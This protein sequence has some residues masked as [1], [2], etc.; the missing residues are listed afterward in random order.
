MSTYPA[1][2]TYSQATHDDLGFNPWLIRVPILMFGAALLLAMIFAGLV[3]AYQVGFSERILPGV[4]T[5][6]ID[7]TGTR[8]VVN[9]GGMT[10]EQAR[11][12]LD[13]TFAYDD[14]TVFTLRADDRFW[15][16]S[17][18]E[19]GVSFDS[20]ATVEDAF[21]AGR[22][23][24]LVG[25]LTG[26]L[27]VWLNGASVSPV[28]RY[29]QG[30][31]AALLNQIAAE[32]NQ[33]PVDALFNVSGTEVQTVTAQSGRALD[34][35][36]TL[37]RLDQAIL[38]QSAGGEIELV[39]NETPPISWDSGIA[40]D[41]ARTALSAPVTL[42]AE[43]ANGRP[44]GP[45]VASVEQI[46]ALLRVD[47]ITN[48]DGTVSYEVGVDVEPFR[49]YLE[50]LAPGLI[51]TTRDARFHFR[52]EEGGLVAI[53]PSRSG[54]T[55]NVDLTLQRMEAAIFDPN[56][57]TV[58]MAFDYTQP[59]YH[60]GLTAEQL[61]IRELVSV[62][63]SNYAGSTRARIDNIATALARFDGIII[64]PGETFSFNQYVGDISPEEGYVSSKVIVGGRT[65]DGVGG[66]VC[67][68]STTAFRAAFYAG[69]PIVER[70]AHG[71]RVGY[72]EADREGVGMDA[73][74]YTPDLDFRFINNTDYHLLIET[75]IFPQRSE[76]E[77]RFYSTNPGWR[78]VKQD[79]EIM[80]VQ[81]PLPTQYEVN[82]DLSPG[83]SLQVDWA[84]EGAEVR[85]TRL[86][87][88]VN[89]NELRRDTFYSNYQPW[90]AI[91]QVPPGEA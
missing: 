11:A 39:I 75:E 78:V 47:T 2:P 22:R 86:I 76:V 81:P 74:I 51:T 69:Y 5:Y 46:A 37:N 85:V 53:Q 25:W 23:E 17:A 77:F 54:R 43:D 36:A 29:D 63:R 82:P 15:Q 89:G 10:P 90:G 64:A 18:G 83:Q 73:A 27:L 61:G 80:N 38:T 8:Q 41:R 1:E 9:L 55:L 84:A 88:D 19:L 60:E 20:D 24:G 52:P 4:A 62:G 67:Q 30:A 68:V 6:T 44:M 35:P 50:T 58:S 7:Q 57:R 91:V 87:V 14:A 66:G 49:A 12:T 40:A 31:A 28:I 32:I 48:A 56:N 21:A 3:A 16:V 33:Q 42:V 79:A 65:I 13:Q 45:W 59:R 26:Q 34:I 70:Y 71:Y 72:Y